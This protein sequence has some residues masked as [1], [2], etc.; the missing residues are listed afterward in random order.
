M[1][2]IAAYH[3]EIT[4]QR[5]SGEVVV[6]RPDLDNWYDE[7]EVLEILGRATGARTVGQVV[8]ALEKPEKRG[9][10]NTGGPLLSV[11]IEK[12]NGRH[13]PQHRWDA[14]I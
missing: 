4:V 3:P 6:I 7:K 14:P 8:E 5:D 10:G 12:G 11:R 13:S 2:K 9:M 1:P